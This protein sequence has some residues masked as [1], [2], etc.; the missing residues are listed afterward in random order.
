[1]AEV[2]RK[3]AEKIIRNILFSFHIKI[4]YAKEHEATL[5]PEGLLLINDFYSSKKKKQ[6]ILQAINDKT[7]FDKISDDELLKCVQLC[8]Q[9]SKYYNLDVQQFERVSKI[10]PSGAW[11][12]KN[13]WTDCFIKQYHTF[14]LTNAKEYIKEDEK[15]EGKKKGDEKEKYT[16]EDFALALLI[17][18]SVKNNLPVII[19]KNRYITYDS[20]SPNFKSI[21]E[22]KKGF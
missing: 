9:I 22:F 16:C 17:D 18:F 10:R 15:E 14:V 5:C 12:V 13:S 1:M 4:A 11:I 8:Q 20:Q 19:R 3:E 6:A 2:T 7:F 21:I